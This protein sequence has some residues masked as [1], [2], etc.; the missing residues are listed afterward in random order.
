MFVTSVK[1]DELVDQNEVDQ[2]GYIDLPTAYVNGVVVG[3]VNFDS[4]F[5]NGLDD[6][7]T[8]GGKCSDTFEAL[9]AASALK[10]A[11]TSTEDTNHA[12]VNV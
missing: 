10:K 2:F 6:P 3:D 4:N 12:T 9:R 8:I 1:Y 11:G 7:S 5:F